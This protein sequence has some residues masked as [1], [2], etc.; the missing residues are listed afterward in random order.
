M[1]E[2]SFAVMNEAQG[3]IH[4]QWILCG[5]TRSFENFLKDLAGVTCIRKYSSAEEIPFDELMFCIIF[6]LPDYENGSGVIGELPFETAEKILHCL[7]NGNTL[8]VENYLAQDYFHKKISSLQIMGGKR[9]F[10]Q[11]YLEYGETLLQARKSFYLPAIPSEA[12][13][14]ATVSDCTGTHRIFKEGKT[15]YPVLVQHKEQ[16]IF[17]CAMDLTRMDV[18][19]MR[20]YHRWEELYGKLFAGVTRLPEEQVKV[21]FR[22]TYPDFAVCRNRGN[23]SKKCVEDSLQWHW[24]SSLMRSADGTKGMYEMIRSNDLKVR[25]NLRTDSTLLTAAFFTAAGKKYG[26]KELIR[27]GC[28]LADFLLERSIQSPEGFFRWFDHTS[29]VYFSDC[30]RSALAMINLYKTTG[31][32]RYL[33][34]AEKAADALLWAL[35]DNGLG[36]GY[37]DLKDGFANRSGNDN[38][39][40][41]GEMVCFLLQ[42]KKPRYT[43]A[44]LKIARRIG[45]KFP[46]VSPFGF[47]DNFTYSRYL[48]ML[49]CLQKS[50]PVDFSEKITPL[51]DFFFRHQMPCGGIVETPIRL[52]KHTEAGVGIGDG[53]DAIADL[54]YCNNFYFNALSVLVKLPEEKQKTLPMEQIRSSYNKLRSFLLSTQLSSNDGRFNGG[55][56]RAFDMEHGEYFGLN[57]DMDWGSYCIMAGWVMAFIPLVFLYEDT[58]EESFYFAG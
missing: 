22:K 6:L 46:Q 17:G 33:A 29:M 43:E 19:F 7:Q 14:L 8:Y 45:E 18:H 24:N 41:Y 42:L 51:L 55:W 9:T 58:P 16:R 56:M 23:D 28:N 39:V 21:S 12:E 20:P 34:A 48:L 32:P 10:H 35:N 5:G 36:C 1:E 31:L 54:L 15:R 30:S 26:K 47:S 44:A 11:E 2:R 37:F 4:K 53:S 52:E 25:A 27:C 49:S 57:K 3:N 38:P 50:A 40:F 13:V